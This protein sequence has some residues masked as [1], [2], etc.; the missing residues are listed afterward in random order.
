MFCSHFS[1]NANGSNSDVPT[2][3]E[4]ATHC[5]CEGAETKGMLTLMVFLVINNSLMFILEALFYLAVFQ[6]SLLTCSA[7]KPFFP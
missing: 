2:K 1:I 6:P 7:T 5:R 4:S 3:T